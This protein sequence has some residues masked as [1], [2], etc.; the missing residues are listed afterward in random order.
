MKKIY[1]TIVL[2][3]TIATLGTSCND[4]LNVYPS[5]QIKEEFL[6]ET[7]DGYRAALNGIYRKMTSWSIY[8][9]NL[10]WGIIDAWGHELFHSLSLRER[11]GS[12]SPMAGSL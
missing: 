10:K 12:Q 1:K 5:D 8:G 7:G 2:L 3:G 11:R 4:W 6:F 9:S